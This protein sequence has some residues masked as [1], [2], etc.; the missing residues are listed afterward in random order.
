LELDVTSPAEALLVLSETYYPGW[1]ARLDD[2]A[3]SV[4]RVDYTLRGVFIAAGQH[5]LQ[6]SFQPASWLWGSVISGITLLTVVA[7]AWGGRLR[8]RRG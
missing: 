4:E 3:T 2:S 6:L 7:V 8:R 1:Q 5:H